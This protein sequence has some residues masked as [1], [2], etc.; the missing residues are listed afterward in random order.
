MNT[1][2][3]GRCGTT[4]VFATLARRRL[5]LIVERELPEEDDVVLGY[6]ETNKRKGL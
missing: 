1:A 6:W 5:L 3:I 2:S 4:T